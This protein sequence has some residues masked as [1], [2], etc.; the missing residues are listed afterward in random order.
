MTTTL[1]VGA[2]AFGL[3]ILL[4]CCACAYT[5]KAERVGQ[6]Q[7]WEELHVVAR[8]YATQIAK[9]VYWR[10]NFVLAVANAC[11]VSLAV[12]LLYGTFCAAARASR[13]CSWDAASAARLTTPSSP[14]SRGGSPGGFGAF[15]LSVFVIC[16]LGSWASLQAASAYFT[17]HVLTHEGGEY[18]A[19]G[20]KR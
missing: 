6:W 7:R 9:R 4:V 8:T 3:V 14:G 20:L 15:S 1:N 16:L 13:A 11:V 10:R 5:E 2:G 18:S 12:A 19:Q 17:F